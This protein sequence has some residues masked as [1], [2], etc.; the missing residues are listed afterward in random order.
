[1]GGTRAPDANEQVWKDTVV[2]RPGEIT[3]IVVPFGANA[4]PESPMTIQAS[5][6][7]EYV[8][9]CHILEHEDNDMMQRFTAWNMLTNGDFYREPGADYYTRHDRQRRKPGP[10]NSLKPS[11]T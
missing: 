2:A 6:I 4:I 10:S 11:A 5:H 7:G 1:M 9:H 8:W 3:R